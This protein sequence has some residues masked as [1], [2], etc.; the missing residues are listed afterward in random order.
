[1]PYK[2]TLPPQL[3]E[4]APEFELQGVSPIREGPVTPVT[5]VTTTS[6]PRVRRAAI[7]GALV[8]DF[9]QHGHVHEVRV[10]GVPG[11]LFLVP[12]A[13][14][15]E[16][17]TTREQVSRGRIWT[18]REVADLLITSVSATDF[19]AVALAKLAFDGELVRKGK[20]S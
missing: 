7:A 15:G 20:G 3:R 1:M 6:P 10:P 16:R 18:A 11:T 8:G 2:L 14:E 12:T 9:A 17:L 4:K 19:S 13:A 5:E